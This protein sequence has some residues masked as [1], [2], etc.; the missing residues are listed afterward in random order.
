MVPTLPSK[1]LKRQL[2]WVKPEQGERPLSWGCLFVAHKK[3]KKRKKAHASRTH[4]AGPLLPPPPSFVLLSC[5]HPPCHPQGLFSDEFIEDRRAGLEE[6]INK[7]S[8]HPL[9]QNQKSL[10]M[11]LQEPHINKH[12]SPGTMRK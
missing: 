2:P 9:A 7:V 10:H 11:F 5:R 8:G 4:S 12:Y 3:E 6:F 1:A